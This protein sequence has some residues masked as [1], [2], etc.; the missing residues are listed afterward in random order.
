MVGTNED[1]LQSNMIDILSCPLIIPE[2]AKTLVPC[3]W[4]NFRLGKSCEH[5]FVAV[6]QCYNT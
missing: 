2:A 5:P 3:F 1:I 6:T 4:N